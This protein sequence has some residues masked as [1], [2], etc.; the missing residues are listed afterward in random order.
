MK[1]RILADLSDVRI[2]AEWGISV[3]C[4]LLRVNPHDN[5]GVYPEPQ[6]TEQEDS[7]N[8]R[9][10]S[11]AELMKAHLSFWSCPLP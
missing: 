3:S 5:P 6:V 4:P 8:I 10:F 11:V 7:W 1:R 9:I 2:L